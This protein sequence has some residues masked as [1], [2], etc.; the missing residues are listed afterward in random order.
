M[1]RAK[2][3]PVRGCGSASRKD[4]DATAVAGVL[5]GHCLTGCTA[6]AGNVRPGLPAA[7]S[8]RSPL[9]V[10]AGGHHKPH[11]EQ[12]CVLNS[13]LGAT[14]PLDSPTLTLSLSHED[15]PM[16]GTPLDNSGFFS[17]I[18]GSTLACPQR[19]GPS[20]TAVCWRC[21][22]HVP[23]LTRTFLLLS[24]HPAADSEAVHGKVN[25]SAARQCF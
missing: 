14:T 21:L 1:P 2:L 10:K 7:A 4:R 17:R 16:D 6:Q 9:G 22:P 19:P 3:L 24:R 20:S 23:F 18:P 12:L 11:H 25:F 8:P 15:V 5:H 13:R